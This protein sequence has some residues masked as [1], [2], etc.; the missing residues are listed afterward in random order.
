MSSAERRGVTEGRGVSPTTANAG[1]S[2]GGVTGTVAVGDLRRQPPLSTAPDGVSPPSS[3]LA[4]L[5]DAARYIDEVDDAT[6]LRMT[7]T[8]SSPAP[9]VPIDAA[10]PP[11]P[12]RY[13]FKRVQRGAASV[14]AT[15]LPSFP[16]DDRRRPSSNPP[17]LTT[18]GSSVTPGAATTPT[19]T[20]RETGVWGFTNPPVLL[21]KWTTTRTA[22]G[23]RDSRDVVTFPQ[24]GV[25]TDRQKDSPPAMDREASNTAD[26]VRGQS[27]YGSGVH[28]LSSSPVLM[29]DDR[30]LRYSDD[31]GSTSPPP[32]KR[33]Y[34]A[35]AADQDDV[36]ARVAARRDARRTEEGT[37]ETE[38][39]EQSMTAAHPPSLQ[40][41]WQRAREVAFTLCEQLKVDEGEATMTADR[42][43][44]EVFKKCCQNFLTDRRVHVP[45]TFSTHGTLVTCMARFV[46][47]F[48]LREAEQYDEGDHG[49][50]GCVSWE[51]D[52]A[53]LEGPRCLHGLAMISK[54]HVVEMDV[55]SENGQRALKENPTRA[56]IITNRWQRNV[57]QLR[58]DNAACCFHDSAQAPGSFSS[59][60]CGMFYTELHKAR[61]GFA[62]AMAFQKACYPRM[63]NAGTHLL[64]CL[65]C[66]CNWE[67]GSG[68]VLGRQVCKLT[69]F[70]LTA[71]G[72]LDPSTVSDPKVR[73]SVTFP[74]LLVFQCCN[75]TYRQNR[76]APQKSCDFKI[77]APDLI[78]AVQLAKRLWSE[79][80]G[81]PAPI[82]VPEY[83]WHP[84]YQYVNTVLPVGQKD[85]DD[86]LF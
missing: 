14:A 82:Y 43:T 48:C 50:T 69:P 56:K 21:R 5:T 80:M 63:A 49:V 73:A 76:S 20:V 24:A 7:E 31:A 33:P 11:A 6:L 8:S 67:T 81:R 71:A 46:L 10:P 66:H 74:T 26:S 9:A 22:D 42:A 60:S 35:P 15:S 65:K 37:E 28:R 59:Q 34:K 23:E 44:L 39:G 2:T 83:R 3:G 17:S 53:G 16:P 72:H 27:R 36:P 61:Q 84:R 75:P 32:P 54:E 64:T 25:V 4:L 86:A 38:D 12:P 41:R 13:T 78:A 70:A 58:H 29:R 40:Q 47:D 18:P 30:P 79:V 68:P 45:L 1:A 51:H 55:S 52:S 85:D 57:V 19:A 62:Q 77:S